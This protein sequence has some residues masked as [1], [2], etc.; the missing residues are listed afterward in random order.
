MESNKKNFVKILEEG[1]QDLLFVIGLATNISLKKSSRKGKNILGMIFLQDDSYELVGPEEIAA[2]IEQGNSDIIFGKKI[3]DQEAMT[4]PVQLE[5]LRENAELLKTNAQEI[6]QIL[7]TDPSPYAIVNQYHDKEFLPKLKPMPLIE[8][9]EILLAAAKQHSGLELNI[10]AE[11]PPASRETPEKIKPVFMPVVDSFAYRPEDASGALLN[12]RG[13]D[14]VP[15]VFGI[16]EIHS[17]HLLE[18]PAPDQN[19]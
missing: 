2:A 9:T 4:V 10:F 13:K 8:I 18:T 1:N 19:Q 6:Y 17:A 11:Y 14:G 15:M 12:G 5:L 7:C 16:E 3:N